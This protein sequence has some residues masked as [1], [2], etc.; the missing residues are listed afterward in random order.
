M[1]LQGMKV[2]VHSID[3]QT[4]EGGAYEIESQLA[5]YV[6]QSVRY[7]AFGKVR[8]HLGAL[9]L[10]NVRIDNRSIPS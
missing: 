4:D 7:V 9:N 5:E 8:S 3:L 6:T 2:E 10:E 1:A